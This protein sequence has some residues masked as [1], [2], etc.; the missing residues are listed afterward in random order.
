MSVGTA[1]A[2]RRRRG[3]APTIDGTLVLNALSS[4]V[5]VV[6]ADNR[7][8]SLNMAAEDLIGASA[9]HA[10]G[11]PLSDWVPEDSPLTSMIEAT[12]T[13]SGTL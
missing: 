13:P 8:I 11:R 4:A 1:K 5:V 10:A 2:T 9:A 12:V 7:V 3:S 6:D